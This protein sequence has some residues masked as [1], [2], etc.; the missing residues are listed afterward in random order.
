MVQK[1]VIMW[2]GHLWCG[3]IEQ[4]RHSLSALP[5]PASHSLGLQKGAAVS[6]H[7]L[8]GGNIQG[9]MGFFSELISWAE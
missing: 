4:P 8:C 5:S 2:S 6:E 1:K 3:L 9:I 7:R